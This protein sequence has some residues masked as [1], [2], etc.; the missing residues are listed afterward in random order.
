[1]GARSV[2]RRYS[3]A[4]FATAK[5]R[6]KGDAAGAVPT[7]AAGAGAAALVPRH[8]H[9]WG[10]RLRIPVARGRPP[11]WVRL[12]RDLP[13]PPA[14]VRSVTLAVRG[15]ATVGGCHRRGPGRL[16][17]RRPGAGPGPGGG[18]RS[19]H[20][21]SPT[22][23]PGPAA[24]RCWCRGGR[25]APSTGC[26]WPTRK[27]RR[28]RSPAARP[29]PGRKA[30]G[31]GGTTGAASAWPRRGTAGGSARP[32]T[33]P[34]KPSSP[35]RLTAGSAPWP[36]AT[37]AACSAQGRA[38]AQPAHPRLAHRPPDHRA[39]RQSRGRRDQ[40]DPGGRARHL[41]HLPRLPVPDPQAARAGPGLPG[42]PVHRPPRP[43]RGRQYRRPIRRR[44]HAG[45]SGR[46]HAPP[47]RGAPSW[48]RPLAT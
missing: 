12:D 14:Q 15:G 29:S 24:R 3:D 39:E 36:S 43:H 9:A 4:W 46:R 10:R 41:L 17:S 7:A 6:R 45:H 21:P 18:S 37:P 11:L 26:T 23:W 8:L 30:R 28:K 33:K 22:R 44:H 1:M 47:R 27:A 2:L 16:L 13:Y 20:H 34:P 32:S 48:C 31:G 5:R 19:G 38:A 35:G 42:L 40:P 25:S